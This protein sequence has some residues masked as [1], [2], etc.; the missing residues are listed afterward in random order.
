MRLIDADVL[1]KRLEEIRNDYPGDRYF[2]NYVYGLDDAWKLVKE[3]Q[4]IE[5]EPVRHGK[6]IPHCEDLL[7]DSEE[8]SVCHIETCGKSPRCPVCGAK[9]DLEEK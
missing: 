2:D 7:G 1:D 6:W 4:I 3:A 8:C 9:M 5:A